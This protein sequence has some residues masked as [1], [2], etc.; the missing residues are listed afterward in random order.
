MYW[1]Y[2]NVCWEMA[3]WAA[4]LQSWG[5]IVGNKR[6]LSQLWYPGVRKAMLTPGCVNSVVYTLLH[7]APVCTEC[8][9]GAVLVIGLLGKSGKGEERSEF[10]RMKLLRQTERAAVNYLGLS[11][12]TVMI[13]QGVKDAVKVINCCPHAPG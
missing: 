4:S 9:G 13:F 12:D 7:A 2:C 1:N 3:A 10:R 6:A 11:E 5:N 8:L